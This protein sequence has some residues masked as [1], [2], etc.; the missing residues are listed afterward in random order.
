MRCTEWQKVF[1]LDFLGEH[2]HR[3]EFTKIT[4]GATEVAIAMNIKPLKSYVP[5]DVFSSLCRVKKVQMYGRH[6]RM[7]YG[8]KCSDLLSLLSDNAKSMAGATLWRHLG[9]DLYVFFKCFFVYI[10]LYFLEISV[11]HKC[12]KKAT[13]LVTFGSPLGA[14]GAPLG[15]FW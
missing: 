2:E 5:K 12:S 6:A 1:H 3:Q 13:F 9:S 4:H 14:F 8:G 10:F 7:S 11:T 15:D